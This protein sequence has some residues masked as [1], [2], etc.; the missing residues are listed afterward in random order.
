MEL[1][2]KCKN[3]KLLKANIEI[4]CVLGFCD[5]FLDTI[6]KA[7]NHEEKKVS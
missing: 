7:Q 1:D 4:R 2:V 6:P 5:E 3:I